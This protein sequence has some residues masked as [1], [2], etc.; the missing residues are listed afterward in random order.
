MMKILKIFVDKLPEG[1][2]ECYWMDYDGYCVFTD[3]AI[4]E[5]SDR[6]PWCPLI[7]VPKDN[8]EVLL[9]TTPDGVSTLIQFV[10]KDE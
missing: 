2:E 3:K 9:I 6:P 1:C 10:T 4:G 5:S 8:N 7:E